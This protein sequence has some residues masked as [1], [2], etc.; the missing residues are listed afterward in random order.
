MWTGTCVEA[1]GDCVISDGYVG[2]GETDVTKTWQQRFWASCLK[3]RGSRLVSLKALKTPHRVCAWLWNKYQNRSW[4]VF[5]LNAIC[6][7]CER[8]FH[9]SPPP[10]S[11]SS[12]WYQPLF[13]SITKGFSGI[14]LLQRQV[15]K[16][17]VPYKSFEPDNIWYITAIKSLK[18][19]E[20]F[21][22]MAVKSEEKLIEWHKSFKQRGWRGFSRVVC[23]QSTNT[24]AYT[25]V[26]LL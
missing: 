20:I 17:S 14:V 13:V 16:R 3:P 24:A 12:T 9:P 19:E 15:G 21:P 2:V 1:E 22:A 18:M 4:I 23:P 10:I 6:Q 7:S 26:V 25:T 8:S 11:P 5:K